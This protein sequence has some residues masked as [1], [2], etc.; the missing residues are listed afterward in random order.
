MRFTTIE[1]LE[2]LVGFDTVSR[3]SNLDLIDFV[4]NYLADLGVEAE[5]DYKDDRTRANLYATV[6][7]QDVGG[8]ALSGHT[9][10][11]PV[12]GQPWTTDPFR[13]VPN[14]ER[15]HGRG[16]VDM[17]GF[18]AGAL[19]LLPELL[20]QGSLA[21]PIH[22]ALS[23]D[24]EVGCIGVRSLIDQL[25]V[26]DVRPRQVIVGEPTSM[27]TVCAHKGKASYR[28]H[29]R[30]HEAHSAL[31]DRGVNAIEAA[32]E[33]ITFLRRLGDEIRDDKQQ[34]DAAFD[35]PYSTVH[36]GLIQGGTQLNIIPRDC[37]FDFEFRCLPG[38]D[39]DQLL[40]R[41]EQFAAQLEVAMQQV[42]ADTGFTWE[43]ISSIPGFEAGAGALDLVDRLR[44]AAGEPL[45]V[46]YG[47]EAG[48]FQRGGM[49]AVVC[50]PGSIRQAHK[51]DE[52]IEL[53]ELTALEELLRKLFAH[54]AAGER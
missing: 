11:V 4:A 41:T 17:K 49:P 3:T 2:H 12:A 25:A 6:G 32:A 51:P 31:T 30:G 48:L 24:E 33:V 14:G 10:V 34:H 8:I 19:A 36:T 27:A 28:C 50:G 22:L 44:N 46:S 45:K 52:Y 38:Q 39:S 20:E 37:Y 13:L 42:V 18:I 7:P 21:I 29:V 47:T 40:A 23:Y 43:E 16:T 53:S 5:I 26:R 35:P 9:D 54:C 15:L 1:M